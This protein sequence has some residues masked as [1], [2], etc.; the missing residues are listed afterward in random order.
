VLEIDH[1]ELDIIGLFVLLQNVRRTPG[2][3]RVFGAAAIRSALQA[4]QQSRINRI[5]QRDHPAPN[6]RAR[7]QRSWSESSAQR[8]SR[9][10]IR[11]FRTRCQPGIAKSL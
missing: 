11:R 7:T 6:F 4:H 2:L 1:L 8:R 3:A 10:E 5:D 9:L